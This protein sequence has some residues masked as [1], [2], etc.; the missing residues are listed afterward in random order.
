MTDH[1][2]KRHVFTLRAATEDD[3]HF[4]REVY[5]STRMN[6]LKHVNWSESQINEF[7]DMQFHAQSTHYKNYFPDTEYSILLEEGT[8]IGRLY[9]DRSSNAFQ[10][11]DI[12]LLHGHR[13]KGIGTYWLQVI[14]SEAKTAQKPVRIHVERFN[15]ALSL[16]TRLG[17]HILEEGDVYHLM[18]YKTSD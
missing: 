1:S 17:F 5:A 8:P 11:I 13:N 4:L 12:A 16:Y 10:I 2:I 15:P 7:I 6:E 14:I 18:E 9:L 3:T